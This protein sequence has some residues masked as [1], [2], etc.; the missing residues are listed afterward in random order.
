MT[1]RFRLAKG[2]MG[3][4]LPDGRKVDADKHGMIVLSDRDAKHAR[5][6]SG[7]TL[8]LSRQDSSTRMAST[9]GK[10]CPEC[11]F[12]MWGWQYECPR[13]GWQEPPGAD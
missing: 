5:E 2:V 6:A 7:D 9:R 1:E 13:C 8:L 12:G 4:Q 10:E 11:L 3:L